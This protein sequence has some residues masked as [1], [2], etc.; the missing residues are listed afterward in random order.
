VTSTSSRSQHLIQIRLNQDH[1]SRDSQAK[2]QVAA[3]QHQAAQAAVDKYKVK[4][5][6]ETE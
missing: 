5:Y 3:E 2:H 6:Y 1:H 4:Y